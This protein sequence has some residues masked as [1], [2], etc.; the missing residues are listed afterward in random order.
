MRLRV[1]IAAAWIAGNA[2]REPRDYGT[3]MRTGYTVYILTLAA[4]GLGLWFVLKLGSTLHAPA[5]IAGN[6][7]VHWEA[8]S[9]TE[10]GSQGTLSIGQSGR[11]CTFRF[12]G[13]QAM[14][15]KIIDGAVLG[16]D[17]RGSPLAR[18]TGDGY[19]VTLSPTAV[20]DTVGLEITGRE[21]RRGLAKRRLRASERAALPPAA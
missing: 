2:F 20:P 5:E 15:L 6:W 19:D 7:D 10:V 21:H 9:P 14:S 13:A 11:F 3:A 17:D 8:A 18:L 16:H 12:D 4:L 1:N